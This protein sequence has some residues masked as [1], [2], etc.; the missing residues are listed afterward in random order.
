[1]ANILLRLDDSSNC[2]TNSQDTV[3]QI[4]GGVKCNGWVYG[5][6]GTFCVVRNG[7]EAI[8]AI[9]YV[10]SI[11]GVSVQD[12]LSQILSSFTESQIGDLKK[13][14]I[15]QYVLM[16]KKGGSMYLFSDFIGA[17][18]IFYSDDGLVVSSSF[19][20]IEDLVQTSSSDLDKYKVYEFLAMRHILYPTWLGRSTEHKRIKWLLPYEYLVIDLASSSF[21]LG[22]IVYTID[23][24]K[25]SD[26]GL[27]ASELLA[28]LRTIIN[29]REFKNSSVAASLTG[30]RD[31]R[32]VAAIAA[33]QFSNIH[34]RTSVSSETF[35]SLKDLEVAKKIAKFRKI[36]LDVY[37]FKPGRDEE[38]FRELTEGFAP[39]Y[40]HSITP[41]IDSAGAYSVGFGGVYGTELF[42]PILC[43]TINE[44]IA[45]RV[46]SAKLV[47]KAEDGFWTFFQE[48]LHDEFRRIKDHFQLSDGDDR[49]YIRLFNLIDTARYSSF[50]LSAFNRT[51]YQLEPYGSY[52]VLVLALSVAPTLWGN[53][54]RLVG[55]ALVQKT[56]MAKLD[57]HLGRIMTY[58]SL[59]PMLPLSI[60]SAPFY[61]MGFTL[62][63]A[64]WLGNKLVAIK[65]KP[66]RTDLPEGYYLSDG[67]EKYFLDRTVKKYGLSVNFPVKIV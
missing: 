25:E 67:W 61:L 5:N 18:N 27:L 6:K 24:K 66:S 56:A 17:R 49:D 12:T 59:R 35:T 19:S 21:R 22:S 29:R 14:L 13:K 3:E 44:Y 1:M 31:S 48:A 26:C 36:P 55:D 58:G 20:K 38:R 53:H 7:E 40:N 34:F 11:N 4:I 60:T 54:R 47:L 64:Y 33:E 65:N 63:V 15:G 30:G 9:G 39:S 50:I 41:L 42:M 52:P 8:A 51:G 46:E 2:P 37:H 32:L 45:T 23:N 62:H 57:P 10:C 43:N 28:T 16:I